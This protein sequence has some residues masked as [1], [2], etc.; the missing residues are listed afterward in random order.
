[1]VAVGWWTLVVLYWVG[2]VINQQLALE[3]V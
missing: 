3:E 1:M 2:K